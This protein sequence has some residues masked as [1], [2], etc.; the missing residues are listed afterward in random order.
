MSRV[1]ELE[2]CHGTADDHGEEGYTQNQLL[3]RRFIL[4]CRA[5]ERLGQ[6]RQSYRYKRS[7]KRERKVECYNILYLARNPELLQ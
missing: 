4:A 2:Q 3:M 5:Q 1:V 7:A 6:L